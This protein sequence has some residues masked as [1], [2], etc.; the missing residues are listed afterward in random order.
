MSD[1][2]YNTWQP[3]EEN[4]HWI[5]QVHQRDPDRPAAEAQNREDLMADLLAKCRR[6]LYMFIG[7]IAGKSKS[8]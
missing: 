4:S 1:G 7:Q 6:Q 5:Q 3:Q 8:L 2:R